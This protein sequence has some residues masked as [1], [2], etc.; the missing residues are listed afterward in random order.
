MPS[1][2]N[3]KSLNTYSDVSSN[4]SISYKYNTE[5]CN[6]EVLKCWWC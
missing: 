6:V 5:M 1:W 3:G 2:I 4:L